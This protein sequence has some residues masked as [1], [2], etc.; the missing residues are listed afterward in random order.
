M[1]SEVYKRKVDPPDELIALILD[2]AA[3]IKRREDQLRR[4][5]RDLQTHELQSAVRL[6]VG[7]V[8]IY[9]EL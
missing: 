6:T 7:F 3:S 9:C 2:A 5:A 8:D 4:T 1:N